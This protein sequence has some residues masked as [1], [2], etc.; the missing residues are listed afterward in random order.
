MGMAKLCEISVKGSD[1]FKEL[2]YHLTSNGYTVQTAVVWKE[3]PLTGIDHWQIVI[4]N[5]LEG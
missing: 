5:E 2:I 1:S 3:F 4:F